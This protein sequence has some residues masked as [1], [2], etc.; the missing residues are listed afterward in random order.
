M[1]NRFKF[2]I[3]DCKNEKWLFPTYEYYRGK[4]FEPY[5]TLNGKLCFGVLGI[6]GIE[7]GDYHAS[8]F[9]QYG[10]H[11]KVVQYTG[12]K[13]NNEVE[14]YEGD[15]VKKIDLFP[16][17]ERFGKQDIGVIKFTKSGWIMESNNTKL[18]SHIHSSNNFDFDMS[19]YEVIGNV[20]ETPDLLK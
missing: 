8:Y 11:F 1:D 18:H 9:E 19:S 5:I 17:A 16:T 2:K 13:D 4:L 10:Y 20:Y 6:D 15:I 14:I 7:D 12:F 3:W